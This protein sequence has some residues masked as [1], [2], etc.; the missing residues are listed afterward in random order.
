MAGVYM[1]KKSNSQAGTTWS[2]EEVFFFLLLLLLFFN[3][4]KKKI[5]LKKC[6]VVILI[7]IDCRQSL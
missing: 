4:N 3:C 6:F 5:E 2:F 1:Y 7:K